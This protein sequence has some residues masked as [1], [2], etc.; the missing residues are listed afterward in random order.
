MDTGETEIFIAILLASGILGIIISFFIL[1]VVK[2]HKRLLELQRQQLIAEITALE[3]ERKRIVA[4]LHDELGPLLATVKFHLTNLD[5]TLK[6]DLDLIRK[7]STNLDNVIH[8][9]REICYHMM[10]DVLTRK[11]LFTAINDFVEQLDPQKT[12]DI[13][14]TCQPISVSQHT[15]LH[16]YRMIQEITNNAFKHSGAMRLQIDIHANNENLILEVNDNGRGFNVDVVM[17]QNAGLG[18][19]NIFGRTRLLNGEMY[20]NSEPGKGT[21][22]KIEIPLRCNE[23]QDT[24]DD[25]RRS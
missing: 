1:T 15:E 5:T 10:P 8:R 18:I 22:Y 9:I 20:L 14:F 17:H 3:I 16:I 23:L 11:G 19:K 24:F 4:D 7:A 25:R 13:I 21:F 2:N 6:N 12:M